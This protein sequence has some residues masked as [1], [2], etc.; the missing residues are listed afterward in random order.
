VVPSND[1]LDYFGE[2]S[3][4]IFI[5][6]LSVLL[7]WA[8]ASKQA[9]VGTWQ[10]IINGPAGPS[11]RIMQIT[12]KGGTYGVVIHSL[13]ESDVP[14]VTNNV[15]MHGS[16]VT[17]KFDM[18]T[19]PWMDY[20][21]LYRATLSADGKS[22]DGTWQIPQLR[23]I[24]MTYT[25]VP[26]ATWVIVEPKIKM[27]KVQ[28][29]VKIEAMDWGGTGRPL[30]W[31]A[32]LGNTGHD[33]YGIVPNLI[34]HYHVYSMTR[35]G[36][37][38]SSK[39]AATSGNYSADRLGDDVMT[40]IDALNIE[41]PIVM[42]HS[43]AGEELSDIGTRFP[44]RLSGLIYVDAGYWYA[45]DSGNKP[46][47]PVETPHPREP[48]MPPV[49]KAIIENAKSFKGPIKLPILAI[50]ANPHNVS[51]D[52]PADRTPAEVK[53]FNAETTAAIKGFKTGLPHAKVIVIPNADHFVYLSN[54]REFLNDVN[55]WIANL[56]PYAR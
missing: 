37:G 48:P 23:P 5:S 7:A 18:S 24:R 29:G 49:A 53:K 21:R 13:D 45:F 1:S 32:G 4:R 56:P 16:A 27:V 25:K 36:F 6:A 55:T 20:H 46:K 8:P 15:S 50:F 34:K 39:V 17:M 42:G 30:L 54:K 22:L 14:I 33:F 11:H 9:L 44:N 26:R 19:W 2:A 3:L 31:L 40:V 43:I 12:K 35:R 38:A 28:R 52:P 47:D 41:K 10:G 51:R